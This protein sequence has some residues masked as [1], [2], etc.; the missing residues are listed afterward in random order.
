[1]FDYDGYPMSA[2]AT[3]SALK[4]DRFAAFA[5]L[6][7]TLADRAEAARETAAERCLASGLPAVDAILG[8]GLLR[9][10]L[11]A[12]E[13]GSGRTAIAAR[14]L[15]RATAVGLAA[16]VDTGELFP[17]ALAR[18]GVRLDRLLIVPGKNALG[19]A[20]AVDILLR[21]R[22]FAVVLMPAVGLRAAVWMR[23]AGLAQKAGAILLALGAAGAEL[24][25]AA[26][27]RVRCTV[28]RVLVAGAAGVFA[29]L[30]GY[31]VRA[32][33]LKHRFG[34]PGGEATVR[35]MYRTDE[36]AVRERIA[37]AP[38]L[39]IAAGGVR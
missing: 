29:R 6:K 22:A 34:R 21:S 30:A 12:L 26:A 3:V 13:G 33:V 31:D 38:M 24:G 25:A 14:F 10:T 8:G 17:P 32:H 1:M 28:D 27:T 16:A 5:A 20:R 11:V 9:G 4:S 39:R 15:A 23:L 35:A 7:A 37:R 19:I 2:S 18:A 36:V